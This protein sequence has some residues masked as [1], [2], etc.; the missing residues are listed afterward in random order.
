MN[1]VWYSTLKMWYLRSKLSVTI[2]C[3]YR[4]CVGIVCKVYI[5]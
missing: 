3:I 1:T 4:I 2:M 5:D